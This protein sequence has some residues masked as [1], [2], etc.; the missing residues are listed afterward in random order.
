MCCAEDWWLVVDRAIGI[1]TTS[2]A[3]PREGGGAGSTHPRTPSRSWGRTVWG[4]H[5]CLVVNT[6]SDSLWVV[7]EPCASPQIRTGTERGLNPLPLPVG[8]ET[9]AGFESSTGRN[10]VRVCLRGS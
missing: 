3:P 2:L 6:T 7:C 8:L 10:S 4:S 9:H 5:G 1:D